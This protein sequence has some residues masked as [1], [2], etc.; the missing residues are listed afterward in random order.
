MLDLFI[1]EYENKKSNCKKTE[2]FTSADFA[3]GAL[4]DLMSQDEIQVK[5]VVNVTDGVEVEVS[6]PVFKEGKLTFEC[7]YKGSIGESEDGVY[8]MAYIENDNYEAEVFANESDMKKIFLENQKVLGFDFLFMFKLNI[9][10]AVLM[11][12]KVEI[13]NFR[14]NLKPD[15]KR[16]RGA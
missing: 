14:F 11:P 6:K 9:E 5:S 3:L 4:S 2:V 8:I 10:S 16:K 13:E 15:L 1:I 12:I 7:D